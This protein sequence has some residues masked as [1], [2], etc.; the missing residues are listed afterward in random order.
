MWTKIKKLYKNVASFVDRNLEVI[1]LRFAQF[2]GVLCV[3][4]MIWLVVFIVAVFN[5]PLP[6]KEVLVIGQDNEILWETHGRYDFKVDLDFIS[7]T[8]EDG[9]SYKIA[10]YHY[11]YA[12]IVVRNVGDEFLPSLIEFSSRKP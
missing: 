11:D 10:I 3:V 2:L 7:W 6:M 5:T 1:E 4:G 8:D 12:S 9:D